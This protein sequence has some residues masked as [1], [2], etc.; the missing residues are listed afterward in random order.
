VQKR[1]DHHSSAVIIINMMFF[2][3]SKLIFDFH[4]QANLCRLLRLR[5][6]DSRALRTSIQLELRR[7]MVSWLHAFH[8]WAANLFMKPFAGA[9]KSGAG[10]LKSKISL[11]FNIYNH[12]D[13]W[14]LI[15]VWALVAIVNASFAASLALCLQRC[16]MLP[17]RLATLKFPVLSKWVSQFL[18]LSLP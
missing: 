2:A 17:F 14:T 10:K 11:R 6:R 7:L 15:S 5:P 9:F 16:K 8:V 4:R 3:C 18:A 13:T 1:I 12:S